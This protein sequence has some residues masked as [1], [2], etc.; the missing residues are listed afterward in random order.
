MDSPGTLYATGLLIKTDVVPSTP[1]DEYICSLYSI[2][3]AAGAQLQEAIDND[4]NI[5]GASQVRNK[6]EHLILTAV[7]QSDYLQRLTE[8][9]SEAVL[10]LQPDMS[11]EMP[12]IIEY[13]QQEAESKPMD[14]LPELMHEAAFSGNILESSLNFLQ[15]TRKYGNVSEAWKQIFQPRNLIVLGAGASV[16]HEQFEELVNNLYGSLQQTAPESSAEYKTPFNPKLLKIERPEEQFLHMGITLKSPAASHP[17]AFAMA[18]LQTLLG[19][20]GSFSS[21]GPG[22]GMYS[23]LFTQVLNRVGWV[24]SAKQL[25]GCYSQVGFFGIQASAAPDRARDLIWLISKHLKTMG[26]ALT[27][28][29]LMRAKN[30]VK[31]AV[32]SGLESRPT[33]LEDLAEQMHYLGPSALLSPSDICSK[34][35]AVTRE[36]V[37]EVASNLWKN[38][39]DKP[40]VVAFGPTNAM[41]EYEKLVSL[42]NQ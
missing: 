20:G 28:E 30:Q 17:S 8:V 7:G 39:K 12:G 40:A 11:S 31:S 14:Y 10:Q 35:D 37:L 38:G 15:N 18:I 25:H 41:P 33:Q 24:E 23:R 32:L 27:L 2:E 42:I 34:V 26:D 1:V 3:K 5:S 21:G 9:V 19:G 36:D 16:E 13:D 29:E 22:K 6:K 4:P